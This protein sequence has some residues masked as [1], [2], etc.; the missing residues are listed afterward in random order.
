MRGRN[1]D[2][3][4]TA[5]NG[6]SNAARA[7]FDDEAVLRVKAELLSS[8]DERLCE[9]SNLIARKERDRRTSGKGLP[10]L[11]RLSS[12]VMVIGGG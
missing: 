6:R 11:S 1:G 7:I 4:A 2:G 3:L 10:R 12:A 9:V 8:E 5:C